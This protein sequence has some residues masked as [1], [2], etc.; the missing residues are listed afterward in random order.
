MKAPAAGLLLI[1]FASASLPAL[2][3]P[4]G[5]LDATFGDNGRTI[6]VGAWQGATV[7]QQP[8]DGKLLIAGA[9]PVDEYT[10]VITVR[11]LNADGSRDDGFGQQGVVTIPFMAG[12]SAATALALQA[13]GRIVVA[14]WTA[15]DTGGSSELAVARLHPDGALD[16]SFDGDGRATVGISSSPLNIAVEQDG[17][18]LLAASTQDEFALVR[19]T[20][21]GTAD[22]SFSTDPVPGVR[23]VSLGN[24]FPSSTLR[25]TVAARQGDGAYILCGG[26]Y[27]VDDWWGTANMGAIRILADAS[28]DPGFGQNGVWQLESDD[29][30]DSWANGCGVTADGSIVV[31]GHRDYVPLLVKLRPDG[32]VDTTAWAGGMLQMSPWGTAESIVELADGDL[33]VLGTRSGPVVGEY[34]GRIDPATGAFDASFG[35]DGVAVI[36]FGFDD[37]RPIVSSQRLLEQGDGKLVVVAAIQYSWIEF[38]TNWVFGNAALA[39]A[40]VD[41]GGPGNN[42]FVGFTAALN[43]VQEDVTPV[44]V[45]VAVQRTGGS[46]GH[47]SVDFAAIA[48]TAGTSDFR[49][50]AG[51][52]VWGDRESGPKTI[53]VPIAADLVGEP[54]ESFRIELLNPTGMLAQRVTKVAIYDTEEEP[55]P[56]VY[57]KGGG[58]GAFGIDA[59]LLL[60][61]AGYAA[62]QRARPGEWRSRGNWPLRQTSALRL[63]CVLV[64]FA[65]LAAAGTAQAQSDGREQRWDAGMTLADA[66]DASVSGPA[67]TSITM[68]GKGGWGVWGSYN[69]GNRLAIGFEWSH[70]SPDVATNFANDIG[71]S[72]TGSIETIRHQAD[73]DNVHLKGTWNLLNRAITPFLEFGVGKSRIDSNIEVAKAAGLD[74]LWVDWYDPW[75]GQ[76]WHPASVPG[77][78]EASNTT[79]TYAIGVRWDISENFTARADLS[80]LDGLE[81]SAVTGIAEFE[82]FRLG[83]GWRF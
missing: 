28:L 39:V 46:A 38:D 60:V 32:V 13:D 36:D 66:G 41:P 17:G 1:S 52:L 26:D 6:T 69:V 30:V 64:P 9:T 62:L 22:L 12:G 20:S 5:E 55:E 72:G 75:W 47:F 82:S 49:A 25:V 78:Y 76:V 70:M 44:A 2:A 11:R 15:P 61:V 14:G 53:S 8:A 74:A 35:E 50:T 18:L 73:I 42:G 37:Q 56:P 67:G 3:G 48:D 59:L 58:S 77:R 81:V 7:A 33:A 68:T 71:T 83:F 43:S 45:T 29:L 19:L 10:T 79:Y 4:G 31:A 40:R 21:S 24:L 54:T 65:L 23:V 27:I 80:G 63:A 57:A 16:A 51:T 34:I